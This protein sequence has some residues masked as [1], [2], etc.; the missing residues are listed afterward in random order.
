MI[1]PAAPATIGWDHPDTARYYAR[2]NRRHG[3]YRHANRAL[4]ER[5]A[6]G[7]G[8][9]VLDVGAGDGGTAAAALA[10]LDACASVLCYEPA[11]AMRALGERTLRD[12]RVRW[13]GTWPGAADTFDR[14]LCG[15]AIW[16]LAPLDATFRRLHALLRPGGCV[17]FDVPAAYVGEP[18]VPGDGDDPLLLLLPS[19][20]A[21]ERHDV[22]PR[23]APQDSGP[24]AQ[25]DAMPDAAAVDGMLAVAGF[26]SQRWRFRARLRQSAYREWLKIPPT[27]DRLLAG[28]TA[29]QRARRINRAFRQV[30]PKSW[31]WEG[32]V[33]WAAWKPV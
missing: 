8:L 27:T 30:D 6:L 33:G 1:G 19:V 25:G 3:R 29:D 31:R 4:V 18:D 10:H 7:P 20:L 22:E 5:A 16:Q 15:A 13:T 17:C 24:V 32:W 21:A 26:Q 12:R 28:L 23:P 9:C 14:V 2:F 11:A